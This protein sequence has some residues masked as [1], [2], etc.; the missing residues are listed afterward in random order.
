MNYRPQQRC[1]ALK[2]WNGS[3]LCSFNVLQKQQQTFNF[4]AN[5]YST[6]FGCIHLIIINR[7]FNHGQTEIMFVGLPRRDCSVPSSVDAMS[8]S[9]SNPRPLS[10]HDW[11]VFS[12]TYNLHCIWTGRV[13]IKDLLLWSCFSGCGYYKGSF[14]LPVKH[15]FQI[16]LQF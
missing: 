11:V 9:L 4:I 15:C 10:I 7:M 13:T 8:L 16:L 2:R 1:M 6:S 14:T 12:N 5:I 3:P